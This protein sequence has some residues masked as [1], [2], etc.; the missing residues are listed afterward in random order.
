MADRDLFFLWPRISSQYLQVR[1]LVSTLGKEA[2]DADAL[3]YNRIENAV[4]D[5][6]TPLHI[7]AAR[8][9]PK[10]C[11]RVLEV[12]PALR[13]CSCRFEGSKDSRTAARLGF[14]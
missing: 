8:N 11:N 3:L 2:K 13:A 5:K 12:A 7:A 14:F 6:S 4:N 10:A 1:H 9:M